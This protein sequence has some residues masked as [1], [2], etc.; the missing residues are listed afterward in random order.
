MF[1]PEAVHS[2]KKRERRKPTDYPFRL[3]T[4]SYIYPDH[5][6][7]NVRKLKHRVDDIELVL[8]EADDAS[9]LPGEMELDELAGI[10]AECGLTYTVHL[11]ID[12][13]LGDPDEAQ[14]LRSVENVVRVI[15]LTT[16]LNPFSFNLHFEKR[17]AG[18]QDIE[19][20]ENWRKQLR[21][22]CDEVL[23]EVSAPEKLAV[24]YLNYPLEFIEDILDEYGLSVILDLGHMILDQVDY[25]D[26]LDRFLHRTSVIHLH[27][28]ADG[29][30]HLS[31][32]KAEPSHL[33][34]ICRILQERNY[35]NVLTLEIFNQRDL[36][37]SLEILEK[38]WWN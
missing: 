10:A 8:F 11:P 19:D 7:P 33:T 37:E 6:L 5:I 13:Y 9:N 18:G 24:E 35:A 34:K 27:G 28:V 32:A 23:A 26:Y 31:L 25:S 20:L 38:V 21:K 3:G 1:E 30:D 36:D 17:L 2:S 22:S 14:R 29:R 15:R 16:C 4:T 12:A